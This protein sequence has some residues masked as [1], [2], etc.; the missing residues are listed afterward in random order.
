[1]KEWICSQ[2]GAREHFA[3]PRALQNCE[4]LARV[5]TDL[6]RPGL[7]TIKSNFITTFPFGGL[8]WWWKL[9]RSRDAY[10]DFIENGR[11]F[12]EKVRDSLKSKN[13][14]GKVFFGYDTAF[15]EAATALKRRGATCI[16]GQMD[17]GQV[18]FDL[19]EEERKIWHDWE[20]DAVAVPSSYQA[21]REAEWAVADKVIVNSE[22]SR[23]S[24]IA[25]GVSPEKLIIVPLCYEQTEI[26]A[27]REHSGDGV[28]DV[29][30]LGQVNLRKGIAYL[31]EAAKTLETAPI[32]F[33]IVGPLK[34]SADKIVNCPKNVRFVG[35]V[36]RTEVSSYYQSA[37][38]FVLPTLSDG[39]ALT[40]LEAMAHGLPVIATPNCGRIV[41]NGKNGFLVPARDGDALAERILELHRDPGKRESMAR[42]ARRTAA[43]FDLNQLALNLSRIEL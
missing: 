13:V 41:I 2:I 37:D 15:L 34:I 10:T 19:L 7:E 31:L 33:T 40:Q 36:S 27:P 3:I 4:K 6:P 5:F 22:W 16:V 39:F 23:D 30:W 17:P 24:L 35:K 1:M 14:E 43:G 32:R 8:R 21:R 20:P 42:E 18:E 28:L 29:L 11:W 26:S 12:S 9:Q 25:Q 38:A